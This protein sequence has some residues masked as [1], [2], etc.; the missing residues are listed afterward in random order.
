MPIP[1]WRFSKQDKGDEKAGQSGV[2]LRLGK[3]IP[4]AKA[5]DRRQKA[6]ESYQ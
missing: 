4:E 2:Y 6:K 1:M 3:K 5:I